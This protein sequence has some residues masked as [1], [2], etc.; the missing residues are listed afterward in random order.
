MAR[1]RTSSDVELLVPLDRDV[2]RAAPPAARGEPP[3]GDPRRAAGGRDDPAVD[4]R[5]RVPARRVARDRRRGVRA[6]RRRGLPRVAGRRRDPRRPWRDEH[7]GRPRGPRDALLAVRLPA[8]PARRDRVPARRLAALDPPGAGRGAC[9]PLLVPRR[10]RRPGAPDRPRRLPQPGPRDG[11]RARDRRRVDRV[12]PGPRP[13]RAGRWRPVARV[14]WPSRTR[15]TPS[16]AARSSRAGWRSSR[17]RS[18]TRASS[19]SGSTPRTSTR[20]L[21]TAA[22][23]YPTGGVLPPER[24]AALVDWADRRSGWVI[25]DDYDAEFRYDREPIGALQ[26]L[27][28]E[29]VIYTGSASKTLA[30]G[31]R[32]GWIAAPPVLVDGLT[33]AKLAADHGSPVIDQ[34][35]LADFIGRGELDRHL[36][37]MRPIY[38]GPPRHAARRDRPPPAGAATRRRVRRPP[39]ARLAAP[40]RRRGGDPR[41]GR[42]GGDR[43]VRDQVALDHRRRA[44]GARVRLRADPRGADRGG[45]RAPGRGH[46]GRP[47]RPRH[48]GPRTGTAAPAR[49]R[50]VWSS[51]AS[52]SPTTA[53]LQMVRS[54]S[55][56]RREPDGSL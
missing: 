55:N 1:T 46:R 53:H 7:A 5:A 31:L 33:D 43:H 32:L 49:R 10:A 17:S 23:Q 48:A 37:R 25:E 45:R 20:V 30:P 51:A 50:S 15:R 27:R 21:V 28:P 36:R 47:G 18:T 12:H 35:A 39:R 4:A 52:G 44:P 2:C 11:R 54:A 9:R 26:G 22:H 41:G 6:A 38:R 24:R 8:R 56:N 3:L 34:L 29:R 19:S 42:R 14:G 13:H 40:R 16:T